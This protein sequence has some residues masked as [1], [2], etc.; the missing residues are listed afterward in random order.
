MFVG[1]VPA[2]CRHVRALHNAATVIRVAWDAPLDT[3]CPVTHYVLQILKR[4]ANASDSSHSVNA[5]A[6][7]V[8]DTGGGLSIS[9]RVWCE[10]GERLCE[11]IASLE[12]PETAD[13]IEVVPFDFKSG[14]FLLPFSVRVRYF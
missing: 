6:A 5:A 12:P 14:A 2:V 3:G 1:S 8:T 10:F 7:P 13:A 4:H 9:R 11:T